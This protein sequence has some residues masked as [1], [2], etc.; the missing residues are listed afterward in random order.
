[1]K[2][3]KRIVMSVYMAFVIVLILC[4]AAFVNYFV[5]TQTVIVAKGYI[6]EGTLITKYNV[7]EIIE[8][9]EIP[10]KDFDEKL[11]LKANKNNFDENIKKL[12]NKRIKYARIKNDR[13]GLDLVEPSPEDS[14]SYSLYFW[15]QKANMRMIGK[16]IKLGPEGEV[17]SKGIVRNKDMVK[18]KFSRMVKIGGENKSVIG[19][20]YRHCPIL[21]YD[22]KGGKIVG[23]MIAIPEKYATKFDFEMKTSKAT[24]IEYLPWRENEFKEESYNKIV[25]EDEINNEYGSKVSYTIGKGEENDVV[26]TSTPVVNTT[27]QQAVQII[28]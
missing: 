7:E 18:I 26:V 19:E 22:V 13:I 2:E 10:L 24:L 23:M 16:Y 14:L 1:M 5:S 8:T 9:K 25:T 27:T 20:R 17:M 3:N 28:K 15:S 11:Y 4:A 21:D 6:P 12:L